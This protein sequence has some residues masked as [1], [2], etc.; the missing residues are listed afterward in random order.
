MNILEL[1]QVGLVCTMK[2]IYCTKLE[3]VYIIVNICV[4]QQSILN[5]LASKRNGYNGFC[6][7]KKT[8]QQCFS[9]EGQF[10]SHLVPQ[11]AQQMFWYQAICTLV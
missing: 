7:C 5:I 11:Q 6:L 9:Y 10:R 4:N 2:C 1:H 3:Y 8:L